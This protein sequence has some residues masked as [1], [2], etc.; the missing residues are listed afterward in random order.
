M[1]QQK[2][3]REKQ[4]AAFLEAVAGGNSVCGAVKAAGASR[5]SVYRWKDEDAAFGEAWNEAREECV[6]LLEA[7]AKR[8]AL[9]GSDTLLIF[10]L[11]SYRPDVFSERV[12]QTIEQ[13]AEVRTIPDVAAR[14]AAFDWELFRAELD[15]QM[16]RAAG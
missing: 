14:V 11:K 13:K 3:T 10:L 15:K 1:R 16:Q 12:R 8:R 4:Q 2:N 7:E 5:A 9:E 6:D